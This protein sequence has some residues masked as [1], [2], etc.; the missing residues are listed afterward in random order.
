[1]G[2]YH[3]YGADMDFA[4]KKK[5]LSDSLRQLQTRKTKKDK[6]QVHCSTNREEL[7]NE[8]DKGF[9]KATKESML[10]MES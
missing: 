9:Y 7:Q 10:N 2:L 4:M 3:C 8:V 6:Y 1:M 5:E